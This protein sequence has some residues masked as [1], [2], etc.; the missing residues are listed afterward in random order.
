MRNGIKPWKVLVLLLCTCG[1]KTEAKDMKLNHTTKPTVVLLP[2]QQNWRSVNDTVMGGYQV[3]TSALQMTGKH[4][5][6]EPFPWKI[7][8]DFLPFDMMPNLLGS[9]RVPA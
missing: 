4:Y 3:E 9:Q 6:Q 8:A 2:E 1:V 7:T 5:F